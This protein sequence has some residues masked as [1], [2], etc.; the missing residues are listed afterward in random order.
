MTRL[1]DFQFLLVWRAPKE[2]WARIAWC[3]RG[4]VRWAADLQIAPAAAK[5]GSDAVDLCRDGA[6]WV[7]HQRDVPMGTAEIDLLGLLA[8]ERVAPDTRRS[9]WFVPIS[10]DADPEGLAREVQRAAAAAWKPRKAAAAE[11]AEGPVHELEAVAHADE[12]HAA[13][14]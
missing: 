7:G 9:A 14:A 1:G 10:R 3:D 8:R 2:G 11:S 4:F 6:K 13:S 5:P 12:G